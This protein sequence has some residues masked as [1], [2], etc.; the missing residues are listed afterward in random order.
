MSKGLA[1][2]MV[3]WVDYIS[4]FFFLLLGTTHQV[5]HEIP[6]KNNPSQSLFHQHQIQETNQL[7]SVY[8]LNILDFFLLII[9]VA[10]SGDFIL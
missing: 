5:Q 2:S 1:I 6:L 9:R 7:N 3:G 4:V 8:P 10:V